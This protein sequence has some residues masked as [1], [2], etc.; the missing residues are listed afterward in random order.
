[1]AATYPIRDDLIWPRDLSQ[2]ARPPALVYLDMHVFINLAKVAVGT[3]T[4]PA[5][6]AQL[7]DAC[8]RARAEGRVL[9]PLSSTHVLETYDILDIGQRRNVTAVMEE[10]SGFHYLLGR[11]Q[12]QE[13]EVE[14]ALN[15]LPTVSVA[16][17]GPV[18][19]VGPGVPWAFGE[20]TEGF[21]F[22]GASADEAAWWADELCRD[23]EIDPGDD[24]LGALNNWMWR[25]MMTGPEDHDDPELKTFGYT[26]AG[27]R[28]MLEQRAEQERYLARQLDADPKLRKGSL[29]DV[30]NAREMCIELEGVL[31]RATAA[32]N[33][34]IGQLLE[35]DREQ[36]RDFT[37]RMP[38]TRVAVSLKERY[39][40]DAQ[41]EWT[42]NDIQDIDAVAIAVPYC[43]VVFADKAAR[44]GVADS[45]ELRVFETV[46]PR[47]PQDL[48]EWLERQVAH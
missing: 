40:R 42:T 31:S 15:D 34:S 12:I 5:G 26:L 25:Q 22:I 45:R 29:R 48:T 33:T 24:S 23:M 1:M 32:L 7:F 19:V 44:S 16:P 35:N 28:A 2:P 3:G 37:D 9:F 10:L 43:D 14:A 27:W 38:S 30:I 39:H 17:Q 6:Y 47:R 4:E 8:R 36:A 21:K 11:P 41:H 18:A 20:R 13:L 46:L